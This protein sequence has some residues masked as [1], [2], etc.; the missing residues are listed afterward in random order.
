MMRSISTLVLLLLCS[1]C[2]HAQPAH[3][4]TAADARQ[5]RWV[6]S[7]YNR[8]NESERIGQLFMVAAYS[9]GPNMNIPKIEQLIN[10][11]MVGGLIFMQGGPQRQANLTNRYQ[12]MAQVPLL[13]A[14]DAEWGLG[15]RLDSVRNLSKQMMIG[16]ANDTTL[17][18][19]L[20]MAVANQCKRMGVHIDFAPVVD[21]NNNP[22]NPVINARSF[23]ED[24]YKVARLGIAYMRGLQDYGIMACAKHFP[25]HGDVSVDSH[26]DMPV[27]SKTKAALDSLELYPFRELI[28][29]GVQSIMVAHLAVPAL[30]QEPHVPTT[31][32]KN[33]ITGLLKKELGFKGLVFTD[34]M[35]MKGVAKYFSAGEADARAFI[36]G[37]DMLLFSQE[38]PNAIV[39]IKAALATG[40]VTHAALETSVKK[41]L[42]AKYAAGL[43]KFQPISTVNI[44]NDLNQFTASVNQRIADAAI[45]QVRDKESLIPVK[46]GSK[47]LYI[48]LGGDLPADALTSLRAQAG[49]VATVTIPKG[50]PTA[51]AELQLKSDKF[52]VVILGIHGLSFYPG[53][54][55]GLDSGVLSF[56][57]KVSTQPKTI[58]ALMGNAYALKYVCNAGSLIVGYEDNEWTDGALMKVLNGTMIPRGTLPVTPPCLSRN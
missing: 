58:I 29:A 20:G 16:A 48:G 51:P 45:T 7:V 31:L 25:G 47:V 8:L 52:D 21:V 26:V 46:K 39:K 2:T 56:L 18:Y 55:Y 12:Q 15:M 32:S 4:S 41:I 3:K 36:A 17:A 6:D 27:I 40:K 38:V 44:T 50:S 54:S 42:A 5:K 22:N 28:R 30:E 10:A 19:A 9:G 11:H 14:M 23:G 13:L 34:A 24:K 1:A 53:T 33:T 43:S 37:N 35:D 49:S 57:S